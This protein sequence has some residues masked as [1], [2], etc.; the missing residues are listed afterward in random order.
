MIII[1]VVITIRSRSGKNRRIRRVR[2]KRRISVT[3]DKGIT[4]RR[5]AV[6]Q[7]DEA[8]RFGE[9]HK[10]GRKGTAEKHGFATAITPSS[11]L[12]SVRVLRQT[13][14]AVVIVQII[15]SH[16]IGRRGNRYINRD[17][18][19]RIKTNLNHLTAKTQNEPIRP[20]ITSHH[21]LHNI[22]VVLK[23]QHKTEHLETL[24]LSRGEKGKA[25]AEGRKGVIAGG[26]CDDGCGCGGRYRWPL[27]NAVVGK[28]VE[29]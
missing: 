24:K 20:H 9:G 19:L 13:K 3:L 8:S 25:G 12:S 21:V 14:A 10:R 11:V 26:R 5:D 22:R 4:Y 18:I 16:K 7:R 15:N 2:R 17:A 23:E 1:R 28:R 6:L 27:W 29:K